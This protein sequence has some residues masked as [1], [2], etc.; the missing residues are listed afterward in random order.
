MK[1]I[2]CKLIP[3]KRMTVL[4]IDESEYKYG[5]YM[6]SYF[7]LKGYGHDCWMVVANI[8]VDLEALEEE[9]LG[10]S[11]IVAGCIRFLNSRP[12]SRYG[13]KR[14][15]KPLYGSFRPK[16]YSFKIRE[17]DGKKQIQVLLVTED[18]KN[19]NFWREGKKEVF[20]SCKVRRRK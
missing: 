15:R 17:K 18:R 6:T 8:D 11:E 2:P 16:P 20:Y 4:Q 13:K 9:G 19:P 10:L 5:Q 3:M 7:P 1:V 12:K 14:R